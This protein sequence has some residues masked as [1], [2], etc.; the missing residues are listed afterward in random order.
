MGK[1]R[2]G[3]QKP[4][5]LRCHKRGFNCT[6]PPVKHSSWVPCKG[7][8]A[9]TTEQQDIVLHTISHLSAY[10]SIVQS[11]IDAYEFSNNFTDRQSFSLW[12]TTPETWKVDHLLPVGKNTSTIQDLQRQITTIKDWLAEWLEKGS[13]PFIHPR[14]YRNRL[15]R[16]VQDAYAS[17]TCYFQKTKSNEHIVLQIVRERA[18]RLLA[19]HGLP[20]T[21]L[22]T[23]TA[24]RGSTVL[25]PL[26]HIARVH[27]LLIYQVVGL[28]DSDI[29][30]RHLSETQMPILTLWLQEMI[31]SA[32]QAACLGSFI[33]LS[34]REQA[35][36]G[37]SLSTNS[38]SD[39][40]LWYSWILAE[41]I[42]R[43]WLIATGVHT[44]YLIMQQGRMSCGGGMVFT[45]RKGVW[46]AQSAPAWEKLCSEV[47]VGLIPLGE[48]DK[49][50]T[51]AAPEDVDR[52]AKVFMEASFGA[53]R[54]ERWGAQ[55]Q[56]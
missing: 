45:T 52:F 44:I 33:L 55:I 19:E 47:N 50:F 37:S 36:L 34:A 32:S 16:S 31:Q 8:D 4:Q 24:S 15:P 54:M 7:D 25:D 12:F 10:T 1:R 6:Y 51:D 17:L 14:L 20:S 38:H 28:Y 39:D 49:L 27:A 43:T 9:A 56:E 3:K 2:C 41:S 21:G 26:E 35:S 22:P 13:N 40:L 42:R 11:E 53:D 18:K 30:L 46:D 5:C 48:A 23:E 29:R